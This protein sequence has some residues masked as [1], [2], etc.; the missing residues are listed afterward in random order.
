L[1]RQAAATDPLRS[2]ELVHAEAVE[3]E[4]R[5]AWRAVLPM[6]PLMAKAERAVRKTQRSASVFRRRSADHPEQLTRTIKDAA[7]ALGFGAVGVAPHDPNYF[8]EGSEDTVA[9]DRVVVCVLEQRYEPTQMGPSPRT[10][11]ATFDSTFEAVTLASKL[12]RFVQEQ[13]YAAHAHSSRDALAIPF[14]VQAGLGQLG[15]NG[16]LLTPTA[17]SRSRLALITTD[18]PVDIDHPIDYGIEG[19]C[20]RCKACVERCPV[21]AIPSS[22]SVHRGIT[23]VK[24]NTERCYPTVAQADGCAVCT[25]VCPIQRFGLTPVL[26]EFER[27]GRILGRGTDDLEGYDWPLDGRHYAPG[28]KPR[29]TR[30][31]LGRDFFHPKGFTLDAKVGK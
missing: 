2:H 31:A 30:D 12:A 27:S 6:V 4:L 10:N 5:E 17:G 9:G 16:Q 3:W 11:R 24:I 28:K 21:G 26:E 1:E 8:C 25:T 18:A 13:G 15:L 14:A 7:L 19:I 29:L 22:R 20:D 23:K